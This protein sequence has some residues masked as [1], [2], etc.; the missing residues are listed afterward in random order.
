[1]PLDSLPL[2]LYLSDNSSVGS[3][4]IFYNLY[5]LSHW[6][7]TLGNIVLAK[8]TCGIHLEPSINAST[9]KMMATREPP[10]FYAIFIR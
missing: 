3:P 5:I 10:E 2:S 6:R 4:S 8:R 7:T 9:V 1:M